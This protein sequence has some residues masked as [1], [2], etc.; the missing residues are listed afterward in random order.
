[1]QFTDTTAEEIDQVMEEA[2]QAFQQYR[3]CSLS[4]RAGLMRAIAAEMDALGDEIIRVTMEETHLPETRLRN[5]RNRTIFQ[6]T[7]YADACEAGG[8]LEA[9]IDTAVPDKAAPDIRKMQVPLGPVV[10]FGA[11]NF[12]YAYS[13]AG[14]D[15]ASALA[16]GCPVIVKAHPAHAQTSELVAEAIAAAVKRSGMPRGVFAHVHGAGFETGKALVMHPHTRAVGFTGSFGGGKALF[17][18]AN[19]RSSPI[20]VFAEMGS[21]NPVFL[22]PGKLATAAG[23][24]AALYTGS[25]TMDKGQFC[26]KPGLIIGL[27]GNELDEFISELGAGIGKILP[28]T[29]LHPGIARAFADKR[30]AALEQAGVKTVAVSATEPGQDQG[31][32]TVASASGKAFL[33]NPV[34]HQEVF[35]PYALVI[36]CGDMEEMTAVARHLEGQLTATLMATEKDIRDHEELTDAIQD[37]CGRLILNGVPTGVR[38]G[39]A[40]QHGGPFPATTDSRFS[41]VGADGIKRWVRPLCYQNWADAL[42]PDALKN[43]NPL[44][45]WRTVNDQLTKEKIG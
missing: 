27:E 6:L 2:W 16:A 18:W 10:V 32:P 14:G 4:Q 38:V 20:P 13:T 19:T 29:M 45:I 43:G 9:R 31:M 15:T 21:I 8:W 36:R 35:G 28:G 33:Q 3:K 11:S 30:G 26:T 37:I 40:M 34:L 25:V 24:V 5:E 12:P 39:L 41:S 17:D 1:M 22:L 23:E 7:S 44:N 42:L